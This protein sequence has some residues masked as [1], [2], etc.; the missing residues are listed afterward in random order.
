MADSD[1]DCVAVVELLPD[2]LADNDGDDDGVTDAVL[3]TLVLPLGDGL[4]VTDDV[5]DSDVLG[6]ADRDIDDDG[7]GDGVSD[8]DEVDDSDGDDV[9]VS[10]TLDVLLK[11][12]L[13]VSDTL[14]DADADDDSDTDAVSEG[15]D[16][17][18]GDGDGDADTLTDGV[19]EE[20]AVLDDE[21]VMETLD[22]ADTEMDA[23]ADADADAVSDTDAVLVTDTLDVA[24]TDGDGD[25]DGDT[26]TDEDGDGDGDGDTEMDDV[27]DADAVALTLVDDVAET[28]VDGDADTLTDDDCDAD[29]VD[30]GV[31]DGDAAAMVT[32]TTSAE[33]KL[34]LA[35]LVASTLKPPLPTAAAVGTNTMAAAWVRVTNEL[36]LTASKAGL[37]NSEPLTKLDTRN[38][39]V[40]LAVSSAL[41]WM[42]N[43]TDDGCTSASGDGDTTGVL[44][45]RVT[46]ST[47]DA[48]SAL[49]LTLDAAVAYTYSTKLLVPASGT[50]TSAQ[51]WKPRSSV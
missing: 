50:D 40:S 12:T 44:G 30:D 16:V 32:V 5:D 19:D 8:S 47:R 11:D 26:D 7:V 27:A 9:A 20:L 33:L 51:Y 48:V 41:A 21:L 34:D 6:V 3:L 22:V 38:C 13:D 14:G 37:R 10:D 15:D 36:L 45:T 28:D 24:D 1:V 18:V 39:V 42:A 29:G 43:D 23:V 4:A 49:L 25:G 2:G 17:V 46:T 35:S 31:G